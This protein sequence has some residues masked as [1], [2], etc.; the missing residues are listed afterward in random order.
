MKGIR[1]RCK[2]CKHELIVQVNNDNIKVNNCPKCSNKFDDSHYISD[3]LD[4]LVT[5]NERYL[6]SVEVL[7][8][9]E[10]EEKYLY[11]YEVLT[12][13]LNNIKNFY[14][15]ANKYDKQKIYKIIDQ[16]YLILNRKD[17]NSLIELEKLISDYNSAKIDIKAEE[18]SKLLKL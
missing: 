17:S 16:L 2:N 3:L 5:Y 11:S 9:F 18:I 4:K 14:E 13:D 7:G 8:V 10:L 15:N 12:E 1:I 6:H